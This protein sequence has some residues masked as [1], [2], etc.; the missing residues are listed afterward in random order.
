VSVFK[1]EQANT[2]RTNQILWV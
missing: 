2:R 1:Y